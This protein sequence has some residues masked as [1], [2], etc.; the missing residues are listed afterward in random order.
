M[1]KSLLDCVPGEILLMDECFYM[2]YMQV[3]WNF[4]IISACF[5]KFSNI[6]YISGGII[7]IMGYWPG[8]IKGGGYIP[9]ICI[10]GIGIPGIGI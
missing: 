2:C 4:I 7:G 5:A 6:L 10:P 1:L 8:I 3:L 9:G